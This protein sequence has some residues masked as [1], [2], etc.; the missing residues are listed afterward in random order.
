VLRKGAEKRAQDEAAADGPMSKAASAL[1]GVTAR[2]GGNGG[3]QTD[4]NP[5]WTALGDVGQ[6]NYYANN[7]LMSQITQLGQAGFGLTNLGKLQA[8]YAPDFVKKQEQIAQGDAF[9]VGPNSYTNPDFS[10]TF[11]GL[12]PGDVSKLGVN[13]GQFGDPSDSNGITGL[14]SND[15]TAF[16]GIGGSLWSGGGGG[17]HHSLG[18]D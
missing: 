16:S 3:P 4:N 17:S 2:T 7:P 18:G 9:G 8:K 10:H 5:G 15:N 14:V 12:G 6:A 11:D 13:L 1:S